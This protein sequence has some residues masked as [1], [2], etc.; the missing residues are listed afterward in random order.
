MIPQS[1]RRPDRQLPRRLIFQFAAIEAMR[2]IVANNFDGV[3]QAAA[4]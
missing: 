2:K 1:R 3:Q 4:T